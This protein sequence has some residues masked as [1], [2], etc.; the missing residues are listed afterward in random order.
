[1]RTFSRTRL[2]VLA[3]AAA[4]VAAPAVAQGGSRPDSALPTSD[5]QASTYGPN[6]VFSPTAVEA[7]LAGDPFQI[8][9]IRDNRWQ[10]DRTQQTD[11]QFSDGRRIRVKWAK[12]PPGG[13]AINNQ[14]RYE[15]AAYAFQK[16]FF[17]E[18]DWVVPPTV[19][20]ELPLTAYRQLDPEAEPTFE[21][22]GSVLVAVQYWLQNV[23]AAEAPDTARLGGD[24]AYARR[25]GYLNLFTHLIR[26]VDSNPGN[27]LVST[28]GPPRLYAVDNGVAFRS[29]ASPRGTVW[30]DLHVDRVP[31]EAVERLRRLTRGELDDALYVVA[32]FRVREDGRLERVPP[33]AKIDENRGVPREE[34]MIQF[35]LT[36]LELDELWARI[37]TVLDRVDAGELET[38]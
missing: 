15:A 10:G 21:G 9:G 29:P 23:D 17:D 36:N 14:P 1:M 37:R 24:P 18:A 3:V 32:Q 6:Y 30:R 38:F 4:V 19:I 5:P 27:V 16:L 11:I 26:H 31:G 34:G 28:R 13:F 8:V 25:L 7:R 20:R 2:S 35:G 22:T 12:A 33:T